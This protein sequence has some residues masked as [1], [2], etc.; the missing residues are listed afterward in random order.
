MDS[1]KQAFSRAGRAVRENPITIWFPLL[2]GATVWVFYLLLFL[3]VVTPAVPDVLEMDALVASGELITRAAPAMAGLLLVAALVYLAQAAGALGLRAASLKGGPLEVNHFFRSI[4]RYA[5]RLSLVYLGMLAVHAVPIVLTWLIIIIGPWGD[6][7]AG[8]DPEAVFTVL[9]PFM[10]VVPLI[11]AAIHIILAMWPVVLVL[12][13]TRVMPS[14]KRSLAFFRRNFRQVST[15]IMWGWVINLISR[16]ILEGSAVGQLLHMGWSLVI[17]TYM[18]LMLMAIY[19][20][21][22]HDVSS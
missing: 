21:S 18:S 22:A 16:M 11:L 6:R 15:I 12:E 13:D 17:T 2:F 10:A 1:V 4:K 20:A 14:L 9:A 5:P 7:M 8:S 19:K 3:V